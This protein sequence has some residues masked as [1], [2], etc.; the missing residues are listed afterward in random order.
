M[1]VHKEDERCQMIRSCLRTTCCGGHFVRSRELIRAKQ[2]FRLLTSTSTR[3]FP[4]RHAPGVY[5]RVLQENCAGARRW[6]ESNVTDEPCGLPLTT[7]AV[8]CFS[9]FLEI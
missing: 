2:T 6:M 5:H 3:V 8:P 9:P 7:Q 1:I 4:S